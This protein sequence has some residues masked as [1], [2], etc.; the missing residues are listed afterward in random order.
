M[1][2][3]AA[4]V[5]PRLMMLGGR[6]RGGLAAWWLWLLLLRRRAWG[7]H[8]QPST[9]QQVGPQPLLGVLQ[10]AGAVGV[11]VDIIGWEAKAVDANQGVQIVFI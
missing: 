3:A 2:A 1:E 10:A 11:A 5:A 9:H 6:G 7:R 8:N 4:V